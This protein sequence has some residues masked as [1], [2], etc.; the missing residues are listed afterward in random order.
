MSLA[1]ISMVQALRIW[2]QLE[3]ALLFDGGFGPSVFNLYVYELMPYHTAETRCRDDVERA[4]EAAFELLKLF[5]K[6]RSCVVTV[7]GTPLA[8]FINSSMFTDG[9]YP[10]AVIE[11]KPCR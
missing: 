10:H 3:Q 7:N 5:E 11:V 1:S 8:E 2:S 4:N 9:L 6:E